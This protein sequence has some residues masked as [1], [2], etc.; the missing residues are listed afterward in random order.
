MCS[1]LSGLY[2]VASCVIPIYSPLHGIPILVKD[3]FLSSGWQAFAPKA[4]S[5]P[6]ALR[7]KRDS[8]EINRL[9][10]AG[11]IT[12]GRTNLDDDAETQVEYPD[13]RLR[14]YIN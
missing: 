6:L 14:Y 10:Q 12:L 8:L 7:K 9:R 13:L 5:L 11:M 2:D 4:S 3:E 1:V